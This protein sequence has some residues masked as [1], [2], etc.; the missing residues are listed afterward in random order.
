MKPLPG[1]CNDNYDR[2]RLRRMS[3]GESADAW[4]AGL[5]DA[6]KRASHDGYAWALER[7]QAE[8]ERLKVE[9]ARLRSA[10]A[11]RMAG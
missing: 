1:M 8:V 5:T 4:W 11:G 9:V 6:Q 3:A 7:A 10:L 2:T